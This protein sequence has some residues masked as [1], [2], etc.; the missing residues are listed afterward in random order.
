MAKLGDFI[1]HKKYLTIPQVQP[2]VTGRVAVEIPTERKNY[3][4][5]F[6]P[7]LTTPPRGKI[8]ETIFKPGQ[9]SI[10][11]GAGTFSKNEVRLKLHLKMN[12]IHN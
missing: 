8:A 11:V 2:M 6:I 1:L 12:L 5:T 3:I 9:L 10:S 7:P 4:S